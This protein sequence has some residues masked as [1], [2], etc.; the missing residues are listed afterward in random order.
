ML[1][2]A[3]ELLTL[4]LTCLRQDTLIGFDTELLG[5]GAR[6]VVPFHEGLEGIVRF[7]VITFLK[8]INFLI[9][10]FLTICLRERHDVLLVSQLIKMCLDVLNRFLL[11]GRLHIFHA[12][13][14]TKVL[15]VEHIVLKRE[16]M[17]G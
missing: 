17:I 16:E 11:I 15:R 5:V 8:L 10:V 13:I 2:L 14:V 6:V 7:H 1:T 4:V 9:E 12:I 3:V